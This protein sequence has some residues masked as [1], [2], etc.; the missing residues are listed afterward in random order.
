MK[1]LANLLFGRAVSEMIWRVWQYR[2]WH[3]AI[4]IRG[5]GGQCSQLDGM[6]NFGVS[7]FSHGFLKRSLQFNC[8]ASRNTNNLRI[9]VWTFAVSVW[10]ARY[11]VIACEHEPYLLNAVP[12]RLAV[13][14]CIFLTQCTIA[15]YW[16]TTT[17]ES[18]CPHIEC[19]IIPLPAKV[20]VHEC[21]SESIGRRK[22]CSSKRTNACKASEENTSEKNN[23]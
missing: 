5:R 22:P 17:R 19:N 18:T 20:R 11:D 1:G 10:R 21:T 16:S 13:E 8:M 14:L 7:S 4:V 23:A 12:N 6:K 2:R 3:V 15:T 9:R